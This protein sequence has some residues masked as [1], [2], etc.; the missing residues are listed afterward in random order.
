MQA[1]NVPRYKYAKHRRRSAGL[2]GPRG[3]QKSPNNSPPVSF[4]PYL[5]QRRT[6]PAPVS[7]PLHVEPARRKAATKP[8]ATIPHPRPQSTEASC[9]RAPPS[10]PLPPQPLWPSQ[11]RLHRPLPS[12]AA[13]RHGRHHGLRCHASSLPRPNQKPPGSFAAASPFP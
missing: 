10:S 8:A 2:Y 5:L 13:R 12:A 11:E 4:V 3:P 1:L 6:L 9:P 7:L